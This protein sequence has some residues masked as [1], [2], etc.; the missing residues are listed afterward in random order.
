MESNPLWLFSMGGGLKSLQN[1]FL[2]TGA[3][4][5][6]NFRRIKQGGYLLNLNY[7]E[8]SAQYRCIS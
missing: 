5:R 6:A 4:F 7:M 8:T 1:V 3:P 2:K